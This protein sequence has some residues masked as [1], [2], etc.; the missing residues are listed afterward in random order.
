MRILVIGNRIPWPLHDGGALASY[1][2]LSDLSSAGH[3]VCFFSFNTKKHFV[4]KED[5]HT[6]FSFCEVIDHYLDAGIRILP[7]FRNLF[8]GGSFFLE[9]YYQVRVAAELTSLIET[10]DFD[11]I[12]IEGLYSYPLIKRHIT[13]WG[14]TLTTD[15]S[16]LKKRQI[17]L[18]Y[19]AHN[20]EHEIWERLANNEPRG[21]KRWYLKI[22]SKRLKREEEELVQKVDGIIAISTHD[23]QY[24]KSG[25]SNKVHLH[26][27]SIKSVMKVDVHV[28]PDAIFHLGSMEWDANVQG[29]K[30]FLDKV[31]PWIKSECPQLQFH[32]AGKGIHQHQALFYQSGVCNHG[33]VHNAQDFMK[34]HGISVIPLLA[35]SGIRMKLIEAMSLGIPCVATSIAVQ[36]L[37]IEINNQVIVA[38]QPKEFADAVIQLLKDRKGAVNLA[39]R[40]HDYCLN[41]HNPTKNISALMAFYKELFSET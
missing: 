28:Q 32:V 14:E 41:Y 1:Q 21:P 17:P 8:S 35:G 19:R 9:R 40:A 6:H 7:A 34:A 18:V 16:Q 23:E 13:W 24:F 37:P 26:L 30:W 4:T 36:G 10:R 38:D 27:P 11:I 2:M 25:S 29:V 12:Q 33:E 39:R 3:E 20:V 22:Q 15:I 31:W 5:I